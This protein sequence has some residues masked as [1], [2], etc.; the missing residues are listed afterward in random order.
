MQ[1]VLSNRI[2]HAI[3]RKGHTSARL[4]PAGVFFTILVALVLFTGTNLNAF[5]VTFTA[6]AT[7][8]TP[9]VC[10]TGMTCD[11]LGVANQTF[12]LTGSFDTTNVPVSTGV[13][14][15]A[16]TNCKTYN[17]P[18]T[19]IAPPTI[20][21]FPVSVTA[22][23]TITVNT[24]PTPSTFSTTILVPAFG[25]NIITVTATVGIPAGTIN[26]PTPDGFGKAFFVAGS[27][28]YTFGSVVSY[29][30]SKNGNFTELT[31]TGSLDSINVLHT[32]TGSSTDG[33]FP[34]STLT[35][36]GLSNSGIGTFEGTTFGSIASSLASTLFTVTN[37]PTVTDSQVKLHTFTSATEGASAEGTLMYDSN[38]L[39][40]GVTEAGGSAGTGTM[41]ISAAGSTSV[42]VID[43][44]TGKP[45]FPQPSSVIE[46][47]D[48][49]VYGVTTSSTATNT[50]FKFVPSTA[51]FTTL[52]T[53]ASADGIPSGPV[54]QAS[55]G[56]FYGEASGGGFGIVY[57][58][59]KTGG[60]LVVLHA[61]NGTD[62]QNPVGGLIQASNG[63]LYGVAAGGTGSGVVFSV[64]LGGTSFTTAHTFSGADG[65]APSGGLM[66]A[67]DNA[68]NTYLFGTTSA[69]GVN[70]FG[71][72]F[73]LTLATNAFKTVHDFGGVDGKQPN[74]P[75]AAL[76]IG[77]DGRL[78]GTASASVKADGSAGAGT[79]FSLNPKL[80]KPLPQ[81]VRF[82]PSSGPVGT[83]VT[84]TGRNLLGVTKVTFGGV[85]ATTIHS[86]GANYVVAFVPTG[87]ITGPIAVTTANGTA[88]STT[89]FTVH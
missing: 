27:S 17:V 65:A 83:P 18:I 6:H 23:V 26:A 85:A 29:V 68:G 25:G 38:G 86:R 88:V 81:I 89:N 82:N 79:V 61:F 14:C 44:A 53:F 74:V 10:T 49:N 47:S 51:T 75:G 4:R 8:G 16:G 13:N 67:N 24:A 76:T 43:P 84:I 56:N 70:S 66:Q 41:F 35:Q 58:L 20:L 30:G 71:T 87:A 64:N 78:Y 63:L 40:Y 48:Q 37:N 5:P 77:S 31:L 12:L 22:P 72:V 3:L 21:S 36:T 73:R 59:T 62:G 28:P 46:G 69:G 15:S 80:K 55:D 11:P 34:Q 50:F 39:L 33:G 19:L 52:Y 57:R 42:T 1:A 7:A 2:T 9:V 45:T 32:F 54:I 60:P